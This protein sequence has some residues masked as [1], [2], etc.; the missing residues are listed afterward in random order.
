MYVGFFKRVLDITIAA[1][2]L[3]FFSPMMAVVAIM[4][5]LE[6][7]GPVLFRQR[8]VGKN[9]REFGFLKFRSM[10]VNAANVPSVDATKIKVTKIGKFIRRTNID[11][12]PQLFNVLRGE[13]SIVGPRPAIGS[14]TAL[15]SMRAGNGAENCLPG[16]TGLAQVNAYDGMSERK[17]R[18]SMAN[19]PRVFRF[20]TILG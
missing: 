10:P 2:S 16:L 14:Q 5:K 8:R 11:E 13:M 17:K 19:T 7:G 6:D 12:L 9:G 1:A 20:L 4:I 18:R 3:I 15:V